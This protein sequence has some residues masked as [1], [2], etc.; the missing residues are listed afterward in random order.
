MGLEVGW[1][2]GKNFGLSSKITGRCFHQE[3]GSNVC[4]KD[5]GLP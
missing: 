5:I 4:L 1:A 2:H 3:S